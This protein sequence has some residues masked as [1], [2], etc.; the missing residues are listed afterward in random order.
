MTGYQE[1]ECLHLD[2][3]LNKIELLN[4]VLKRLHKKLTFKNKNKFS[5][6]KN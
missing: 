3:I 1:T 5:N 6:C 2:Y 4:V